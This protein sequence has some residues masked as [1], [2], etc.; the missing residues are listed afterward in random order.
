MILVPKNG[1]ML[2]TQR[3]K[4]IFVIK[5]NILRHSLFLLE[6]WRCTL[7]EIISRLKGSI[8]AW[9]L[10]K[11]FVSIVATIPG[12]NVPKLISLPFLSSIQRIERY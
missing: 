4:R 10:W 8:S 6:T 2:K 9:V 12:L 7:F 5:S 11:Q 1:E 3:F